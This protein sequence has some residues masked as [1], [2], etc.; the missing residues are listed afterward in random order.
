MFLKNDFPYRV[1]ISRRERTDR[2][3]QLQPR[4]AAVGLADAE[5]FP[6]IEINVLRGDKR[7]FYTLKK[8]SLALGKRLILREAGRR[9]MPSVLL[10]EDDVVFHPEFNVRIQALQLPK[11]WGIFFFGCQHVMVPKPVSTGV[12]RVRRAIDHHAIA[13]RAEYFLAAR[14]AMRGGGKGSRGYRHSDW[15]LARQHRHIPTYAAFPNL[16]WQAEDYSDLKRERYSHYDQATGRQLTFPKT[17]KILEA[18][19]SNGW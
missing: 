12:V 14:K 18:M 19:N 15:L 10:L 4:L 2:R 1:F 5:W 6:A 7:G 3:T 11:N 16:A 13:I 17:K 9:G 8:R